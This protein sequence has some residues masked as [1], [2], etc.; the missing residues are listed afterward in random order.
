MVSLC[1]H[2]YMCGGL[3]FL[4]LLPE[5][6]FGDAAAGFQTLML[7]INILYCVNELYF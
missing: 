5:N 6:T 2:V 4:V 1:K 7:Q 3:L